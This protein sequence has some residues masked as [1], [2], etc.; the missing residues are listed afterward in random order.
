VEARIGALVADGRGV[1]T[2]IGTAAAG[3]FE[4]A[5]GEALSGR[6]GG[7][8][9]RSA[10]P[11]KGPCPNAR[12]APIGINVPIRTTRLARARLLL[13]ITGVTSEAEH[14]LQRPR[15]LALSIPGLDQP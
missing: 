1:S 2:T 9:E 11:A 5:T 8:G 15:V 4:L 3:R 7:C 6:V 13:C 10:V 14:N 12:A